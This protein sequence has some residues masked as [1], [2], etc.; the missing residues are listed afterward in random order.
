M[1]IEKSTLNYFR[2]ETLLVSGYAFPSYDQGKGDL[3]SITAFI[4][5]RIKD[6]GR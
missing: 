3:H 6:P 2:P 1:I 4:F 5:D